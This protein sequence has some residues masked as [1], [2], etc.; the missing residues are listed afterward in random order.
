MKKQ[1]S[2]ICGVAA[3]LAGGLVASMSLTSSP[4]AGVPVSDA[5]A[6]LISGGC[7]GVNAGT[8]C[9]GTC[10]SDTIYSAGR[11]DINSNPTG[12]AVCGNKAADGTCLTSCFKSTVCTS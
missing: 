6:S 4:K 2:R 5:E 12:N 11:A 7:T 10:G 1:I 9:S 3:I 8:A